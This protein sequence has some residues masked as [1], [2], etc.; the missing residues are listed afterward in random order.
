[1]GGGDR[2]RGECE[3]GVV[4][5]KGGRK[6]RRRKGQKTEKFRG[7]PMRIITLEMI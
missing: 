2:E 5:K 1:M 7:P 3:K 4:R 6:V